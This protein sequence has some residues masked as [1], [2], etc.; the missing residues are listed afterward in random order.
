MSPYEL[1][2]AASQLRWRRWFRQ[3]TA[4]AGQSAGARAARAPA[5]TARASATSASARARASATSASATARASAARAPTP[6]TSRSG[7][8]SATTFFG[9]RGP[10]RQPRP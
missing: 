4:R 5:A 8:L 1:R 3:S 6:A 2:E 10:E 7:S 9:D